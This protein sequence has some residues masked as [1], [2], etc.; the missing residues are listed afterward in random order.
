MG[1]EFSFYVKTDIGIQRS[2]NED[3]FG[4]NDE[5]NLCLVADGMGGHLGGDIAAKLAVDTILDFFNSSVD[6]NSKNKY[7]FEQDKENVVK[8]LQTANFTVYTKGNTNQNLRD[9]GTT[10]VGTWMRDDY[11]VLA[12]VGDSRIYM[13]RDG[14]F[15]QLTKDHSW[16]AELVSKNL[17]PTEEAI[18]HPLKNIITRAIGIEKKVAIDTF[19]Q[20]LHNG[21]IYLL[22]TDGLT[23]YV[24]DFRIQEILEENIDDLEV[25]IQK[26]IELANFIA[27]ADNITIAIVKVLQVENEQNQMCEKKVKAKNTKTVASIDIGKKKKTEKTTQNT[28]KQLNHP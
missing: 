18:N 10:I 3:H 12:S 24:E 8:A 6:S 15:N 23:D 22:C 26:M 28:T 2:R 16:V 9:M 17:L 21:D 27:G 13:L 7:N 19:E 14:K 11:A 25:A 1:Y 20:K 5:Y 4:I